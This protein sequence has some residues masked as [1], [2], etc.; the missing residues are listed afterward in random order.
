MMMQLLK[1][2]AGEAGSAWHQLEFIG[3]MAKWQLR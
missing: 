3:S 1:V 2:I